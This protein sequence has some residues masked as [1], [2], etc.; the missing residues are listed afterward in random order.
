MLVHGFLSISAAALE[1]LQST[2]FLQIRSHVVDG[3]VELNKVLQRDI[4]IIGALN[5][6]IGDPIGGVSEFYRSHSN[7]ISRGG[8]LGKGMVDLLD[9]NEKR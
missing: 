7:H 5:D 9:Q 1:R 6:Q 8:G 4:H 3:H 2:I